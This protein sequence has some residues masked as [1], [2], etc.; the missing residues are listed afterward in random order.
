MSDLDDRLLVSTQWL[1]AQLGDPAL[2]VYDTTVHLDPG[3][4]GPVIRSGRDD[5]L[6]G[7]VPGAGFLD[8][9]RDLSDPASELAF[10]R[11]GRKQLEDTF[12]RA[13]ISA[14]SRVVLYST[15]SAMWATRVW[16]LLRAAGHGSVSLLDGGFAKWRAEDRRACTAPCAPAPDRFVADPKEALWAGQEEVLAALDGGAACVVNALPRAYHSG[17]ATL[18]YTRRGRIQGSLNVPFPDL[19]E[20]E[21]DVLRP[22]EELRRQFTAAGAF[23]CERVIHYCGGAIAATLN[24]FALTLAGHPNVAVYDGSLDEWSRDSRLPMETDRSS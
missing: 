8:L 22:A 3:E 21:T 11:P 16:W 14:D 20:P 6:A 7:H 12:S 2:R 18:G 23:E 17:Q 10:A 5:Y 1:E 4:S 15:S 13:G 19:L 9:V 24:A